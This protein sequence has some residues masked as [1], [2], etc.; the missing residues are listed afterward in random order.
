MTDLIAEDAAAAKRVV[1]RYLRG[2]PKLRRIMAG[3]DEALIRH[4]MR[5][6]QAVAVLAAKRG[7][8]DGNTEHNA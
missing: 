4:V 2:T 3:E 6:E 8:P 5:L 7:E 1:E